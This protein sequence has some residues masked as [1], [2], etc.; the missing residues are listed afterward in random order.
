MDEEDAGQRG[1]SGIEHTAISD[2]GETRGGQPRE[3]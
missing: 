1:C 3:G 2:E